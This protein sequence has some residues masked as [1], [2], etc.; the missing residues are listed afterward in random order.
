MKPLWEQMADTETASVYS[1]GGGG[2][3]PLTSG[4]CVQEV[5]DE[6]LEPGR[7]VEKTGPYSG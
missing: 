4:T 5:T 1:G 7:H 6:L 2:G 3:L